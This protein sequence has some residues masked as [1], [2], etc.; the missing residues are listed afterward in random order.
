M[1]LANSL[2]CPPPFPSFEEQIKKVYKDFID[3]VIEAVPNSISSYSSEFSQIKEGEFMP[4]LD[5]V[6]MNYPE[7]AEQIITSKKMIELLELPGHFRNLVMSE[8]SNIFNGGILDLCKVAA[9]AFLIEDTG[10]IEWISNVSLFEQSPKK[11]MK[12]ALLHLFPIVSHSAFFLRKNVLNINP[13]ITANMPTD[14]NTLLQHNTLLLKHLF[15]VSGDSIY[16]KEPSGWWGMDFHNLDYLLFYHYILYENKKCQG[17][18]SNYKKFLQNIYQG[19]NQSDLENIQHLL[20]CFY[21]DKKLLHCIESSTLF[22]DV[23]KTTIK[24][25]FKRFNI[26]ELDLSNFARDIN[27]V[28]DKIRS[29]KIYEFV[30]GSDCC[31]KY[32]CFEKLPLSGSDKFSRMFLC[33]AK[34]TPI[35]VCQKDLIELLGRYYPPLTEEHYPQCNIRLINESLVCDFEAEVEENCPKINTQNDK[36]TCEEVVNTINEISKLIREKNS[37]VRGNAQ[38]LIQKMREA[39]ITKYDFELCCQNCIGIVPQEGNGTFCDL[40]GDAVR[41]VCGDTFDLE[42][43]V[44]IVEMLI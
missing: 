20:Q 26:E 24:D 43:V 13:D 2:K 6:I 33:N 36:E 41:K 23:S 39:E 11:F 21:K 42:E 28:V 34:D 17:A 18:V 15:G 3:I 5:A 7:K 4:F 35:N 10:N 27:N 30:Q 16:V 38:D 31:N 44:A 12:L 22:S 29:R 9:L 1:Y 37:S 25:F 8:K 40:T 19:L 32:Q 14:K